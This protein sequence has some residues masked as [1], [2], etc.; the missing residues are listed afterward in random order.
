MWGYV[1]DSSC[2]YFSGKKIDPKE[3]FALW[4]HAFYLFISKRM[5]N[6][7]E[8]LRLYLPNSRYESQPSPIICGPHIK[9]LI[10]Q[11]ESYNMYVPDY[12]TYHL[13]IISET[14]G[15]SVAVETI[16]INA[17]ITELPVALQTQ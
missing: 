8:T 3:S 6:N 17:C 7:D 16:K 11:Q 5:N 2:D 14:I 9:S 10:I 12:Y 15:R 13:V 4:K 1:Y